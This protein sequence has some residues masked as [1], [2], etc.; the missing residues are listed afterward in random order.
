MRIFRIIFFLV[1]I[2]AF[3]GV[4][5]WYSVGWFSEYE[6][7]EME[8][9]PYNVVYVDHVWD[10]KMMYKSMDPLYVSLSWQWIKSTMWIWIFH[11]N[12][13]I[14]AKN[15]LRSEAGIV[16]S[17]QE[18]S[19]LNKEISVYK[20]KTISKANY[21]VVQFPY[22]NMFSYFVW[23]QKAYPL[24]WKYLEDKWYNIE[25]PWIEVYDVEHWTIY[26][27]AEMKK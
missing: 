4:V 5:M 17:D 9:W 24:I 13:D 12:P 2:V 20:I 21:V 6:A 7:S 22:V 23:P 15:K 25:V 11:D 27:M 10:Y 16:L 19:K 18:F 26:Y 8:M 1:I 14:V 3:W